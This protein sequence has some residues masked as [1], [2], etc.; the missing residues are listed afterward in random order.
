MLGRHTHTGVPVPALTAPVQID[1][2]AN[3]NL[4]VV[5][6]TSPGNRVSFMAASESYAA[7][8][9]I[10]NTA[11]AACISTTSC[12]E[13]GAATDAQMGIVIRDLVVS[14]EFNVFVLDNSEVVLHKFGFCNATDFTSAP[15][16]SPTI[17][18]SAQ[19]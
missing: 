18:P 9:R 6:N 17:S 3:K 5:E 16:A 1:L 10:A 14:D 7:V 4:Y 11:G 2:D 13:G 12:G 15:I 19:D 8:Y